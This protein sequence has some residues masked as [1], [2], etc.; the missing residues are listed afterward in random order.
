MTRSNQL[1]TFNLR[2]VTSDKKSHHPSRFHP[3]S[4]IHSLSIFNF[5]LSIFNLRK[6]TSDKKSHHPSPFHPSSLI[7]SLSIVN[8]QIFFIHLFHYFFI[9]GSSFVF[10][11]L[12][13]R[14]ENPL[15]L[16]LLFD[17]F[18]FVLLK[19]RLY[20]LLSLLYVLLQ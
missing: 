15:F 7:H 6:V 11:F 16:L 14:M 18:T 9:T 1:S 10:K 13:Q 8:F 19:F 20:A 5:Q 2:K 3:S 4:L 17:G 12:I